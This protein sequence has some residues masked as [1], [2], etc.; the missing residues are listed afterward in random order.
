M[1]DTV[2]VAEDLVGRIMIRHTSAGLTAGRIVEAEA[3]AGVRDAACH[4][5]RGNR[6]GR[7]AVMYGPGGFA[8]VYLI[9]GMNYC[10]NVV[11]K[12]EGEP[13]AVLIR[14]LEPLEGVPLMSLRRGIVV[15]EEA[16]DTD[17]NRGGG[18]RD[19]GNKVLRNLCSGPGK[20]CVA[21]AIDKSCYG[22]D[23]RGDGLYIEEGAK[24]TAG[25]VA[26]TKRV[27]VGYAGEAAE[28]PWR[29]I[30]KG[31]PFLSMRNE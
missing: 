26:A 8:Y 20:L 29:F 21:M 24:P 17:A 31:S 22:L 6:N 18:N 3:Y 16:R 30:L 9:Y 14:A 15:P 1:R 5:A 2:E 28:Y 7:T 11:T 23:L 13:E 4:S 19:R 12:P 10:M 27:N 25:Q